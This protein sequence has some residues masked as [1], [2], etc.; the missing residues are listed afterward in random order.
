MGR[1]CY[2]YWLVEPVGQGLTDDGTNAPAWELPIRT[3]LGETSLAL[4]V[5]ASA[6]PTHARMTIP[7]L[8]DDALPGALLPILQTAREHLLT[9]LRLTLRDEVVL[10]PHPLWMFANDGDPPS[11]NLAI[12]IEEG[13]PAFDV[14]AAGRLFGGSFEHREH[15]RLLA[16]GG[17]RSLPLQFRFLSLYRLLELELR[18]QGKWDEQR[19]ESLLAPHADRFR[20]AGFS[21]S[22]VNTLH[23]L[24]DACAHIRSGRGLGV[25][26]LNHREAVR[27]EK[28]L[29]I[30]LDVCADVL[31]DAAKGQFRVG[32]GSAR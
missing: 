32:R 24:R 5:G 20:E 15:L 10:F 6:L 27:V 12:Q 13:P 8:V 2:Y 21:R 4:F 22:P 14:E 19:L 28:A 26:H 9:V 25:T 1:T 11:V 16:D 7:G 29:P 17:T 31:N 23:E 3:K 18:H 30:L